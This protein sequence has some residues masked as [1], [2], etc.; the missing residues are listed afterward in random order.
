MAGGCELPEKKQ[1]EDAEP[2]AGRQ[3]DLHGTNAILSH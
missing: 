1:R 2:D 3:E